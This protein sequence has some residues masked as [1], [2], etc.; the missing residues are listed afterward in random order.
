MGGKNYRDLLACQ[1]AM[2]LVE[3][4]YRLTR[5]FPREE[6]YGLTGQLRRA[7]VSVASNIAEGQG[8]S[9]D[10]DFL[11]FLGIAY[12][13]L[14]EVETQI[15]IAG[16]LGY[17]GEEKNE[18]ALEQ[19]SKV[20]RLLNGLMRSL[21]SSYSRRHGKWTPSRSLNPP[22][23]GLPLVGLGSL[24]MPRSIVTGISQ[25]MSTDY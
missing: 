23:A 17:I 19:T 1:E 24:A 8:R 3:G 22:N 9:T 11:H 10:R 16:R 7:A 12:G 15:L 14:R 2:D 6:V 25:A 18:E 5:S 21:E 4:V 13:S 20:G